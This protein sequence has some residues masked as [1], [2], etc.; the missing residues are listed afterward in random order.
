MFFKPSNSDTRVKN[1]ENNVKTGKKKTNGEKTE[2][3]LVSFNFNLSFSHSF[4]AF[5]QYV[6]CSKICRSDG[7][8]HPERR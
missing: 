2:L 4:P 3:T 1:D 5:Q 6:N 8:W 7:V